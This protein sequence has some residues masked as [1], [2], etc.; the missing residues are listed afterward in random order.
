MSAESILMSWIVYMAIAGVWYSDWMFNA[1]C[2]KLAHNGKQP[3]FNKRALVVTAFSAMFA[4]SF[5]T[6]ILSATRCTTS[7]EG[8]LWGLTFGLFDFGLNVAHSFFEDRPLFFRLCHSGCVTV[9]LVII[10]AV[11]GA[12]CTN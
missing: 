12:V 8:G 10:G 9:A 1:T 4:L 2:V 6:F 11:L 7:M 5:F 3:P